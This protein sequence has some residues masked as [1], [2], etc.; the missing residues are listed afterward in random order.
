MSE[1]IPATPREAVENA[2]ET[3]ELK[4]RIM[5]VLERAGIADAPLVLMR[6]GGIG[7]EA[8]DEESRKRQH[9]LIEQQSKHIVALTQHNEAVTRLLE[10]FVELS[11]PEQG[12]WLAAAQGVL[13][14]GGMTFVL[15]RPEELA[16]DLG[17]IVA[18]E[19]LDTYPIRQAEDGNIRF[20]SEPDASTW[21]MFG[22]IVARLLG[23]AKLVV[24]A[25]VA[26]GELR[27]LIGPAGGDGQSALLE[28]VAAIQ[29]PHECY[30]ALLDSGFKDGEIVQVGILDP[31][32]GKQPPAAMLEPTEGETH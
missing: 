2:E 25:A 5:K 27:R 26:K 21:Q 20:P 14:N 7:I 3:V 4:A 11:E 19:I 24:P 15:K 8:L 9:E 23:K 22:R 32:S 12:G 30:T 13:T 16:I 10:G 1:Q 29:I 18:E 31:M 6:G 17:M 28:P